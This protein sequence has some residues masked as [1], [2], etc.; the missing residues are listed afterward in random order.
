MSWYWWLPIGA[1]GWAVAILAILA[2]FHEGT[3]GPHPRPERPSIGEDPIE[4]WTD[5]DEKQHLAWLNG[6]EPPA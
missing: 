6:E 4:E 3:R 2:L 5:E 1:L